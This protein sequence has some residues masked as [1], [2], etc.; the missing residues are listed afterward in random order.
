MELNRSQGVVSS[1]G[2]GFSNYPDKLQ[3]TWKINEPNGK[4]VDMMF[5]FLDTEKFFDLLTVKNANTS[6]EL[7]RYSGNLAKLPS[8]S[9]LLLTRASN[10]LVLFTSDYSY[11]KKGFNATFSIGKYISFLQAVLQT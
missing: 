2:F 5:H 10:L 11:N 6:T 3:C 4:T 1:P 8:Q 7:A 9:W